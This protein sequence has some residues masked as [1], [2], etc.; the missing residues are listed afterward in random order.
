MA[1]FSAGPC[2]VWLQLQC[3]GSTSKHEQEVQQQL[4]LP[5]PPASITAAAAEGGGGAD[6]GAASGAGAVV[7]MRADMQKWLPALA[8]GLDWTRW[9]LEQK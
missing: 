3:G 2:E 5:V 6:M 9:A 8:A 1:A 4:Q 7:A